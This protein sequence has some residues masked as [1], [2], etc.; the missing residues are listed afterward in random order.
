MKW[1]PTSQALLR[2]LDVRREVCRP[3]RAP[4]AQ[5]GFVPTVGRTGEAVLGAQPWH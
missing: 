4:K 2:T 3:G 1:P 5:V